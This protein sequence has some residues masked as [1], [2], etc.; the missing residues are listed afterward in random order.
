METAVAD[1]VRLLMQGSEYG[2]AELAERMRVELGERLVS[3]RAEGRPLRVYC[4][5]DPRTAD[6]HLGHTVPLRKLR[7]FQRLGHTVTI[8]VGTFTSLI[9][10]PS[11]TTGVR[12]PMSNEQAAANGRTYAEQA[13]RILDPEKTEVRFNHEWLSGLSFGDLIGL[14]SRFS[15][16]QFLTRES[17]RLRWKRGDAVYLHETFYSLMQGYD[18]YHLRA[19]VQ[20]G[21][22]DQVFNIVTASRKIMRGLG[23]PPN[24]ALIVRILPGVDGKVK[25]SKS[26]GNHISLL[27][28]PAGMYGQLMSIPDQAMRAYYEL[29]TDL[30]PDQIARIFADLE[31]GA[32]HPRDVKMRLAREVVSLFHGEEKSCEAEARFVRVFQKNQSPPDMR[33]IR[34]LSPRPIVELLTESGLAASRSEARRLVSQGGVRFNGAP[35][36]DIASVISRDGVLQAGKRRFVRIVLGE[37]S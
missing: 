11:D 34:L 10:D 27:S 5:F 33:A 8:V 32:T 14:A 19:D 3:A 13:F 29:V 9:G 7:Q 28:E 22:T 20:V 31:T 26:L 12:K 18:A 16:Q 15:L 24:V 1:Q 36:L 37:G 4:G 2:D 25:M 30:G 17:F 23:E 6:L 35:V 21:G